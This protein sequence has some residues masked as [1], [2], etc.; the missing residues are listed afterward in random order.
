MKRLS[1]VFLVLALVLS[2]AMC[3]VTAYNYRDML[4]GIAHSC[5][6]SPAYVA[7][8]SALPFILGIAVCLVLA[9]VLYRNATHQV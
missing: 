5:Y 2:H 7:F 8:F 9:S 4:C 1:R 6:S 3:V